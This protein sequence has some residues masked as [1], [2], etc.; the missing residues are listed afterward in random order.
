MILV[1]STLVTLHPGFLFQIGAFREHVQTY[2]VKFGDA[3]GVEHGGG[4][5][6]LAQQRVGFLVVHGGVTSLRIRADR[7]SLPVAADLMDTDMDI[8]ASAKVIKVT[9]RPATGP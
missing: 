4:D 7:D 1:P 3:D 9:A 5:A 6:L 2:A 8:P